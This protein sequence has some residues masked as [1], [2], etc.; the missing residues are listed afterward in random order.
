MYLIAVLINIGMWYERYVIIIGSPAHDYDPYFWRL[1]QGPT[2]VEYGILFGAFSIFF[3]FFFLFAKFLPT[4]S[5]A[6]LKEEIGPPLR[7]G[8]S[9]P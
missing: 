7:G 2:W 4:V 3:F 5:I 6:D 1:Y 8:K 9:G